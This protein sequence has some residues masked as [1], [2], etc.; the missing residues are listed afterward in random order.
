M[1]TQKALKL[2]DATGGPYAVET[3]SPPGLYSNLFQTEAQKR[4][5]I[6]ELVDYDSRVSRH[7]D[8]YQQLRERGKLRGDF[9]L[10]FGAPPEIGVSVKVHGLPHN[11]KGISV[12]R[13]YKTLDGH[14][15]ITV[16]LNFILNYTA[17]LLASLGREAYC[18]DGWQLSESGSDGEPLLSRVDWLERVPDW[19]IV[20]SDRPSRTL[21]LWNEKR[22]GPLK[23]RVP[24][25]R[26]TEGDKH[27]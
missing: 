8:L 17:V 27:G 9:Y 22:G 23:D 24:Q 26:A 14:Y 4:Y 6:K 20:A 1:D 5:L 18:L 11:E 10:R 2:L 13:C 12:F 16:D 21:E 7:P 3:P 15:L 25:T 19:A